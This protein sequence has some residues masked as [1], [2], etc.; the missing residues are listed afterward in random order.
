MELFNQYKARQAAALE[1]AKAA[2]API[3][4]V[5]PDGSGAPCCCQQLVAS[6]LAHPLDRTG[7]LYHALWCCC[8]ALAADRLAGRCMRTGRRMSLHLCDRPTP[9]I[10]R[11]AERAGVKGLTTPLD[12][13]NQISKG[14]AKKAVV[15]KVGCDLATAAAGGDGG[16]CSS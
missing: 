9:L 2:N 4:I 10:L 6:A 12:I 16:G 13:A 14:L 8:T 7:K 15:A 1:A 3:R 5:L 11:S